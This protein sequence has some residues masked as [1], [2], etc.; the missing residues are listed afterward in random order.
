MWLFT[1]SLNIAQKTLQIP[2]RYNATY[3]QRDVLRGLTFI[4]L[5]TAY[6]EGG[7]K[8]LKKRLRRA[9]QPK[10]NRKA[11]NGDTMLL[12]LKQISR[13]KAALTLSQ[14]NQQILT[15]AKHKGA[16]RKK[17]IVAID[18]TF[19]PYYGKKHTHY[20]V[21][22]KPKKE[23]QLLPLLGHTAHSL[24]WTPIHPQS[25]PSQSR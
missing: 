22:G 12:R 10:T 24:I 17:V 8:R 18:L 23:N 6:A 13:K 4:S 19:I 25:A 5:E 16:F 21:G 2:T 15:M 11:P 7:L 20:I 1:F 3:S 9:N 14:L